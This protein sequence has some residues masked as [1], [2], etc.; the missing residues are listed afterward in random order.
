MQS[1]EE[2]ANASRLRQTRVCALYKDK[3]RVKA[4]SFVKV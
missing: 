3:A 1:N 4:Q 2:A